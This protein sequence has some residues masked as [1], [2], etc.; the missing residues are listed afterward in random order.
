V[1]D[2]DHQESSRETTRHDA[3]GSAGVC[4]FLPGVS[5][6]GLAPPLEVTL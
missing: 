3:A 4:F 2:T 1:F 5:G 6:P